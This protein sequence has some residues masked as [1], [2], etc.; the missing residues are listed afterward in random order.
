MN[1]QASNNLLS[2]TQVLHRFSDFYLMEYPDPADPK[3]IPN[4]AIIDHAAERGSLVHSICAGIAQGIP[5]LDMPAEV[6]GYI[7]SFWNWF[8]ETVWSVFAVEAELIHPAYLYKG[9]PDMIVRIKGDWSLTVV[10]LKTP[11]TKSRTWRCQLAAY[12]ELGKANDYDIGRAMALRLDP[13]GKQAKVIEFKD[14]KQDFAA[15]LCALSALR[16]MRGEL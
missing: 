15:F 11:Q 4:P 3:Y 12:W 2:V 14:H 8:F 16:Y 6:A 13:H 5:T 1:P 9:H 7:E 10:D